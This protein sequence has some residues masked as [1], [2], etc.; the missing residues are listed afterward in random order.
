VLPSANEIGRAGTNRGR[1]HAYAA[2]TNSWTLEMLP[3]HGRHH[4]DKPPEPLIRDGGNELRIVGMGI[5]NIE[6]AQDP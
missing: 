5:E 3:R 2:A 6:A 4:S 1:E